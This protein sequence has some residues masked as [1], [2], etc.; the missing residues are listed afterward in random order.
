MGRTGTPIYLSGE[1]A[2]GIRTAEDARALMAGFLAPAYRLAPGTDFQ[3]SGEG[4]PKEELGGRRYFRLR[5]V[6][7]GVPVLGAEVVV[8]VDADGTVSAVLGQLAADVHVSLRPALP[9]RAA[10]ERALSSLVTEG[11]GQIHGE[12]ALAVYPTAGGARLVYGARV[13]YTGTEGWTL[14]D[15]Y[16]GADGGQVVARRGRVYRALSRTLYDLKKVCLRDGSE[17]PGTLLVR[18]GE[19]TTDASAR[20]VY[21][22]SGQ[23][24]WYYRHFFGRD[25]FDD[26][27]A[28]LT[29]SVHAKFFDGMSCS[30]D[31]AA[32]LPA[33]YQQMAY[34]DGSLILLKDPTLAL[35]VTAHELTHA[36]TNLTSDLAYENE[37]G[38]LNE[39]MSD[40][41]GAGAEAWVASGGGEAGNPASLT[42]TANTWKIG[43]EVAGLLIPGGALRFMNNPTQD[44][45]SKDY[46]PERYVGTMD[47][48]G[49]HLN[50]GIGNLA[51]YLLSQG[52]KHPKNKTPVDV[53]G[54]GL[55]KALRIFY[56]ANTELF[57]QMIDFAGARQASAHAARVRYGRCSAEWR[58]TQAAWDAV[59]VPGGWSLCN[60]G[61]NEF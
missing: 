30:A 7:G 53:T 31:N 58:S 17:L 33:P 12:P 45:A 9:G 54:V 15:L 39:A 26:R 22:K 34:G 20:R 59:G 48:G 28:T 46:Y 8:E 4:R 29:A 40:I 43:E 44:G 3:V 13:E 57:T 56:L 14:E 50:S 38:A 23:T 51:F 21:D 25:S 60:R 35:D 10:M 32:W 16:A 61:Q 42:V 47:N 24:Y 1:L 49:V 36:V 6:H 27:G 11:E 5:Q 2:A 37:S 55:E 19:T 18:E 52:G 41:L